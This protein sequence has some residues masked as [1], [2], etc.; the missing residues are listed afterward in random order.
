MSYKQ[1][2]SANI[3]Y[4]GT[5]SYTY[6]ASKNGGSSSVSYHG[7]VP[8]NVTINVNTN[9]FD[10][11]VDNCNKIID[12][13]TGSVVAMNAAQS[14]AIRQTAK[15]VS[16]SLIDGFFGVINTELSQQLQALDSAIKASLGLIQEQSRAVSIQKN[17]MEI[18]YNRISSRYLALFAD[19]D[20]ECY[21]RIYALDKQSFYL[22]EKAQKQLLIDQGANA[23]AL[24]LLGILEES[25]SKI[26]L[27]VSR[28]NRKVKEVLKTLHKYI[29]QEHRLNYLVNS[30]LFNESAPGNTPIYVPIICAEADAVDSSVINHGTTYRE[31]FMPVYLG[32]EQ[33]KAITGK[34]GAICLNNS[35]WRL[36]E[37]GEKETLNKEFNALTEQYFETKTSETEQRVYKAMLS[38]WQN[39][40]QLSLGGSS[41]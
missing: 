31:T 41:S 34:I 32:E 28:L 16:K 7:E 10:S 24:S 30:L 21:K 36:L 35:I 5:I 13:L 11:S 33:K 17:V 2:Y 12:R 26:F 25:S 19:L 3:P 22:S 38:L 18:D 39:S 1:T 27:L 23:T 37:A 8:L 40:N 20:N 9:P 6:P 14:V 29:T 4:S 15:E